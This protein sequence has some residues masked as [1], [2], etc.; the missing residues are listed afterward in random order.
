MKK[1]IGIVSITTITFALSVSSLSAQDMGLNKDFLDSLPD[2]VRTDVMSEV[3][4]NNEDGTKVYTNIPT[5]ALDKSETLKKWNRFLEDEKITMDKSDIFGI[6]FFKS[7][8]ST[9]SPINNPNFDDSYIVDYGDSLKVQIIGQV[10]L[11]KEVE[12]LRDGT[13]NISKI[14]SFSVAGLPVNKIDELIKAKVS[15]F[16]VGSDAFISLS[17]VRDIQVSLS[18]RA[19]S[20][21]V[22]T[23]SGNSNIIHLLNSAGGILENGSF[24][25]ILIKRAGV[26][27]EK[28]D[29]YKFFIDG[30][31]NFKTQLKSGDVVLI[32]PAKSQIRISGGVERPGVYELKDDE[33]FDDLLSFAQ[34]FT[35]FADTK[36]IVYEMIEDKK[37]KSSLIS[38]NDLISISPTPGKSLYI[39]QLKLKQ[40]SI[41]GAVQNPGKYNLTDGEKLSDLI[42]RAGGYKPNA[43]PFGGLLFNENAKKLQKKN[44]ERIYARIIKDIAMSL[45]SIAQKSSATEGTSD[46]I[47]LLLSDIKNHQPDGRVVAEFDLITLAEFP[48]KDT[49]LNHNDNL[50]IPSITEQVFIFGEVG[51]PGAA[52]YSSVASINNYLDL[53]GGLTSSADS[54]III[55]DP[56]GNAS[57]YDSADRFKKFSNKDVNL[58]PGSVIYVPNNVS[59]ISGIPALSIIA[60]IFSS[61]ALTLASLS[62]LGD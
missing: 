29:L 53:R 11:E 52:R 54:K 23:L 6:N 17:K 49:L 39:N 33:N 10:N 28:I 40:V 47:A 45:S 27:I 7:F 42:I 20:P 8:Q 59:N 50:H 46:V 9:F 16:Y 21:G 57:I 60:P 62:S 38:K 25:E 22:Y 55:I 61:F 19:F 37:I 24:R 4:K 3:K 58:Y 5:I 12:V 43:Y 44:N 26:I 36:N 35:Y 1:I 31:S 18:G 14:G 13:I 51:V 15:Q 41:T 30:S 2:E 56:S 34:G 32:I 48:D